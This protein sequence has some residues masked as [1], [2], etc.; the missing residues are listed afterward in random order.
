MA[1]GFFGRADELGAL[2]RLVVGAAGAGRTGT[3]FVV[4][5]A[6]VGKTRLV[7]EV[8]ATI[9]VA[10][11]ARF[12]LTGFE[13]EQHVPFAAAAALLRDLSAH[14]EDGA[15]LREM[16]RGTA[17]SPLEPIRL[18][19]AAYRALRGHH[20]AILVLD[21]IQWA[22]DLSL[23]LSHYLLR[24]ADADDRCVIALSASRPG[25]KVASLSQS[26]RAMLGPPR[27][28]EMMLGPLD[29]HA[30]ARLARDVA[31]DLDEDHA[32]ELS[33]TA[34]GSPFWIV[35]MARARARSEDPR[36]AISTSVR[37]LSADAAECLAVLIVAS[38]PMH[39]T[40]IA[41]ILAWDPSRVDAAVS[42]LT[43]RGVVARTGS[44]LHISHDVVRESMRAQIP[45][46]DRLRLRRSIA[47]WLEATAGDDL[48]LLVEALEHRRA[49]GSESVE[50]ALRVARSSRRRLLGEEGLMRLAAIADA[51]PKDEQGSVLRIEV[52][53][54][55]SEIGAWAVALDRW[56]VLAQQLPTSAERA[57]AYVEAA[58]MAVDLQRSGDAG[59]LLDR[60]RAEASGPWISVEADALDHARY[61]WIEH[62]VEA[63]QA[64]AARAITAARQL[65]SVAGS[66][67]A[68][69][70][71][72]RRAYVEALRAEYDV[73]LM[74]EDVDL[75]GRAAQERVDATRGFEEQHL[76]ARANAATSLWYLNRWTDAAVALQRVFEESQQQVFPALTA[77]VGYALAYSRYRIGDIDEALRLV[78]VAERLEKRLG[79][80]S[81]RAVPWIR[82]GI[83]PK[84]MA[85]RG[86]WRAAV[87]SLLEEAAREPNP[88]SRL[89]LLSWAARC[90]AH[91][92]GP[93]A[94]E[95]VVTHMA[96]AM[97]DAAAAGCAR[98]GWE[99]AL[100][101][102][103]LH[104][105][106]REVDRAVEGL[107][108]WEEA[109]PE[110]P[111]PHTQ[112]A[113]YR[114]RAEAL[115]ATAQGRGD[116]VGLCEQVLAVTRLAALR[117][118]EVWALIDLGDA[119]VA[120]DRSRAVAVWSSGLELARALDLTSEEDLIARR[121]RGAG[122]RKAARRFGEDPFEALS[123]RELE[124][125]RL[126]ASG[127]RNAEIAASLF[128]SLK[129]VE[130]H[131]S[132]IFTKLGVRN[133]AELVARYGSSLH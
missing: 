6:G 107:R 57:R 116:A 133:R 99:T 73:A 109:H 105:R 51:A 60:A 98:C 132:N 69:D 36:H 45:Q 104:A 86:D 103:E 41:N 25:P 61:A 70:E 34:D 3:A 43:N 123:A 118:D 82:G 37:G 33:R 63:A 10:P 23:G 26:L 100:T 96:A 121:L 9:D 106:V 75:M 20:A 5:D 113:F 2:E 16:V 117:P 92:G 111:A 78:D 87:A 127:S 66:V 85:S 14:P 38:R 83:R 53:S 58:R 46:H 54:I 84:I 48:G 80:P 131:L 52:A 110:H 126:A 31:P 39:T 94:R 124:V 108:R 62:D 74:G 12:R 120:G 89:R 49:S 88:H 67:D 35:T 18:F 102:V 64:A 22:D 4:G 81:R 17:S 7:Q 77:E 112:A 97:A 15:D 128:I 71:H 79:S 76:I 114:M 24:A 91:F 44:S 11:A 125:L 13:P 122:A 1:G 130:R 56:T 59:D 29:L 119:L 93:E 8:L 68:L 42:E 55:A 28:L 32:E 27:Y 50:L 40:D 65:V 21:D 30:G 47:A 72:A 19:E 95:D 115:L 90:I 129:T 101:S